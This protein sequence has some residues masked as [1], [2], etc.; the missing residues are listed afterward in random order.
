MILSSYM[1]EL[2]TKPG[3]FF[4]YTYIVSNSI[5]IGLLALRFFFSNLLLSSVNLTLTIFKYLY[6]KV[7]TW[8]ISKVTLLCHDNK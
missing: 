5:L 7:E 6:I 4:K 1:L 3:N 8:V 2:V